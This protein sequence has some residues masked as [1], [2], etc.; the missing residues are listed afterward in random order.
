[1]NLETTCHFRTY[2]I[3]KMVN[4]ATE[5]RDNWL[6]AASWRRWCFRLMSSRLQD[7]LDPFTDPM[8]ECPAVEVFRFRDKDGH[9]GQSPEPR[10]VRP[11]HVQYRVGQVIKHKK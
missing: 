6:S 2:A 1:M 4:Q 5:L 8:G 10:D 9:F 11:P 3:S 7:L